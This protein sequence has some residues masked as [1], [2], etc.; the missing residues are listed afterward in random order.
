MLTM[1]AKP[2]VPRISS[3]PRALRV[4]VLEDDRALR[5]SIL[6]P[7]LHDHGFESVGVGTAAELYRCMLRQTFDIVL[8]D[9]G[10]P[11]ES[12][13]EVMR[14]LRQLSASLGIVMLTG[15]R[16]RDKRVRALT[17]GA[18]AFLAKPVDG[19][20]L[21]ATLHSLVRRLSSRQP[22]QEEKLPLSMPLP[23]ARWRLE[24]GGWC[25]VAPNGAMLALTAQ[26][27]RLLAL[28]TEAAG[29]PVSRD[30]LLDALAGNDRDFDPHRLEML[31][32]RLRRKALGIS[33]QDE[34]LPLLSL[35]GVGY[36]FA[37]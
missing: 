28:L 34:P 33:G 31:V 11:D 6:L 7:T 1:D 13:L 37:G 5:E 25:L 9:I 27:R 2:E 35:R 23:S 29:Q 24:T 15:S 32:H 3:S 22:A 21:A 16:G 17:D 8:L 36:L 30:A 20:V 10:L 14:H 12:G 19:E 26:E 18:D 4:A